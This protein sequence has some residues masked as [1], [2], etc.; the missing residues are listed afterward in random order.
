MRVEYSRGL[1]YLSRMMAE[2]GAAKPG[3][4]SFLLR[5]LHSS[6]KRWCVNESGQ[7]TAMGFWVAGDDQH[8]KGLP[9]TFCNTAGEETQLTMNGVPG[10]LLPA[11]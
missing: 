7:A 5:L 4:K 11:A 6:S 10:H 1:A 2:R 8:M 9:W 3:R